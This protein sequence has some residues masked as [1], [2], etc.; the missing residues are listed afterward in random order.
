MSHLVVNHPIPSEIV[1][2]YM[3]HDAIL[4]EAR[5]KVQSREEA[6][7]FK[8]REFV[9]ICCARPPKLR[10]PNFTNFNN[11]KLIFGAIRAKGEKERKKTTDDL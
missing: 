11:S 2:C 4:A 1:S 5:C 3:K 9:Y 6:G 8:V 7:V 10:L